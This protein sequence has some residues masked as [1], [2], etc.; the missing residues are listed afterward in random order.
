MSALGEV[1]ADYLRLR[2]SLGYKLVADERLLGQFL[3]FLAERGEETIT[4]ELAISWAGHPSGVGPG[5]IARRLS[6]V[7]TFATFVASIDP[8]T[9]V[10]PAGCLP[11]GGPRRAVPYLYTNAEVE[12]IMEAARS[13]P[14]PLLAHTYETL[15]GLLAVTGMRI[16]EA[17]GLGRGDVLFDRA[18][19]QVINGK[20]GKSREVPLAPSSV[21]ALRRFAAVRDELAPKPRHDSFFCSTVGTGL[22]YARVRQTFSELCGRAG[23]VASSPRCRPR[24]HDFRHRYAV[25]TL[26]SWQQEGADIAALLPLLS[27]VL[28][29]VN[30]ANTYWYLSATPE[31]LAPVVARLE[32]TFEVDQ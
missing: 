4:T 15:I 27:T 3:D 19:V 5:W 12:A 10:P 28:G 17:L 1:L 29:H 16:G 6:T 26:V 7:R 32:N 24:L 23:V 2:R 21:D 9:Q 31:L 25:L 11:G 20:L 22:V 13:L 8:M 30:P 14:T 18:C